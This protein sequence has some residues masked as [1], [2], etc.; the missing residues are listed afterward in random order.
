MNTTFNLL[1]GRTI[2]S[3]DVLFD[4]NNY[5]FIAVST[6][7]DITALLRASD[8]QQFADFDQTKYN[9]ILY[10]QK[11][12]AAHDGKGPPELGS[13]STWENFANQIYNAPLQAP[14]EQ[15][16]QVLG[17]AGQTLFKSKA[18]LTVVFLV[19]A[20]LVYSAIRK[21]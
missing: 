10:F 12:K 13:A 3:D 20:V 15:L 14:L 1:D 9:T 18:T 6:G 7:A 21:K 16:N 5:Q 19:V 8:K 2:Y 17:N 4:K 11:Y